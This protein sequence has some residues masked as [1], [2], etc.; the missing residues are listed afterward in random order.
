MTTKELVAYLEGSIGEL[1][2]RTRRLPE[3][4]GITV[5]GVSL[6]EMDHAALVA[7]ANKLLYNCRRPSTI[8]ESHLQ[9]VG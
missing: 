3:G 8:G 4:A 9:V 1:L 7:M 5:K 6:A 2:R